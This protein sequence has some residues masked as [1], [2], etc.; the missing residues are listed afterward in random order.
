MN[1]DGESSSLRLPIIWSQPPPRSHHYN[2][3]YHGTRHLPPFAPVLDSNAP[4]LIGFS[5]LTLGRTRG[6][7]PV[8]AL[9]RFSAIGH[10]PPPT[11]GSG[12]ERVGIMRCGSVGVL[13]Q[14]SAE[15]PCVAHA[16]AACREHESYCSAGPRLFERHSRDAT[17]TSSCLHLFACTTIDVHCAWPQAF[18]APTLYM[19]SLG[20]STVPSNPPIHTNP[21]HVTHPS[22]GACRRRQCVESGGRVSPRPLVCLSPLWGHHAHGGREYCTPLSSRFRRG[23]P[24]AL[25][26]GASSAR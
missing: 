16:S 19:F 20:K 6:V 18:P 4:W 22:I 1:K 3:I 12:S 11:Q 9:A 8:H 10:R 13:Q 21:T 2:R 7:N 24:C 26:A 14:V 5:P 17:R 15:A 23:F 25:W